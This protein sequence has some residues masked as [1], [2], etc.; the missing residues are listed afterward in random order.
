MRKTLSLIAAPFA[1]ALLLGCEGP[2]GPAGATG[3][4]GPE[5]PA[6]PAGADQNETCTQCHDDDIR[7]VVRQLQWGMS[8]HGSGEQAR[9]GRERKPG[10]QHHLRHLPRS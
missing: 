1:V 9:L 8:K 7:I 5:G 4:A 6:G 2:A 10:N 3:A